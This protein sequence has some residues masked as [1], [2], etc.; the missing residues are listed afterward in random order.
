MKV[1]TFYSFKG[2]V[3]RS[4]ALANV[5]LLLATRDRRVLAVDFDL[6][7][8]GLSMMSDLVPNPRKVERGVFEYLMALL[9]NEEPVLADYLIY[10]EIEGVDLA[11][12]PAGNLKDGYDLSDLD[13]ARLLEEGER[14]PLSQFR[15]EIEELGFTYALLD[16]RT[17]MT[18]IA[19]TCTLGLADVVV[20]LT[21][22]NNQNLQGTRWVLDMLEGGSGLRSEDIIIVFSP[23][24]EAEEELKAERIQRAH[25]IVGNRNVL[26]LPYHPRLALI[27]ELFVK[28]WKETSLAQRYHQLASEI[29]R[30]NPDDI[31]A[32]IAEGERLLY[33]DAKIDEA[34]EKFDRALQINPT[35][36]EAN[37]YAGR[38]AHIQKRYDDAEKYYRRSIEIDDKVS[39]TWW[40]LGNL[41]HEQGRSEEELDCWEQVIEL[42]PDDAYAYSN[43]GIALSDLAMRQDDESLFDEAIKKYQKAIEI[44][45]EVEKAYSNWGSAL[46]NL[47]E[48][49]DDEL[50]FEDAIQKYQ[51]AIEIKPD[52]ADA[53]YNWGI[54]LS[55]LA[56]RQ[57]DESLFEEA[58]KKYQKAIEINPEYEK[59]YSN[60]GVA[61]SGLAERQDDESLFE[62]AIKKYQKAIEINPEDADAYYNWGNAL[63]DLAERRDDES[64]F[65]KAIQIYQ[66]ALS[67]KEHEP[68]FHNNLAYSSI[69]IGKYEEAEEHCL[70]ALELNEPFFA[71][72]DT[73]GELLL[74]TGRL[75]EA[76]KHFLRSLEL[77]ED[78]PEPHEHYAQL[79]R[80][81]GRS[82][83]AEIHERRAQELRT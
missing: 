82:E 83:E 18:E 68:R 70:R 20:M 8:P 72:H 46:R 42:T 51:K 80:Q 14:N 37:V 75:E 41:L 60:W 49:R 24:P 81:M 59:A 53:Y 33:Q 32:I 71:A 28:E 15:R 67:L 29:A 64:L 61:L 48:H 77:K 17:G 55:D 57:D 43:W 26:L 6:E 62:E 31:E 50:L 66:R 78:E 58:I 1:V 35:N 30:R 79:L 56:L 34:K 4:L 12:L 65:E 3:G 21:G 2:G 74:K 27:E 16:S 38:I 52:F 36:G 13:F 10:P 47:A 11:F 44:N 19:A 40:N 73:Y 45:P 54:T 5:S 7:A 22:L 76:E 9:N 39:G 25:E 63:S 69:Q 23:V